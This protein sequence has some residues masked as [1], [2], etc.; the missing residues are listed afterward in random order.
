MS[1]GFKVNFCDP[2]YL[3]DEF[4]EFSELLSKTLL[5]ANAARLQYQAGRQSAGG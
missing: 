4:L 3:L 2:N 1:Q 5:P